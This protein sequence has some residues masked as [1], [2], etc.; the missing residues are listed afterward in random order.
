MGF[1]DGFFGGSDSSSSSSSSTSTQTVERNLADY[2]QIDGG[3]QYKN[4]LDLISSSG[5]NISLLDGGSIKEAFSYATE[6][7]KQM[8]SA[9]QRAKEVSITAMETTSPDKSISQSMTQ[10][11]SLAFVAIAVAALFIFRK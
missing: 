9:D 8:G 6:A 11:G 10:Y 7:L 4:A 1:F 3:S 2:T 5:N